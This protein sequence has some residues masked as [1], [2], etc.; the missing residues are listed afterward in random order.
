MRSHSPLSLLVAAL[1]FAAAPASAELLG[2]DYANGK[3]AGTIE[4]KVNPSADEKALTEDLEANVNISENGRLRSIEVNDG[5]VTL[6]FDGATPDA[7]VQATIDDDYIAGYLP[8][9]GGP[10]TAALAAGGGAFVGGVGYGIYQAL[11]K[12]DGDEQ[13]TGTPLE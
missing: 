2:E 8:G 4:F 9:A 1:V 3:G 6:E 7:L 11:D 13:P 5:L 10:P 12:D